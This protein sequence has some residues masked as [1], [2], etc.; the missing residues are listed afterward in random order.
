MTIGA[1]LAGAYIKTRPDVEAPDLQLHFLPFMPGD[2]GRDLADFRGF[3][4][5]M[6]QNRPESRGHVRITS[7]D[8]RV[9]PTFV[10]NHLAE[11][12]DVQTIMAGMKLAKRIGDAMPADVNAREIA[13]GPDG[14]TDEGLL[15]YI[16]STADTG[17]HYSGS[18][19]MGND[20][21]SVVDPKL[22]VRGVDKLRVIDAS[23]L[24]TMVS[25]NINAD[26]IMI[27]EKG[28]DLVKED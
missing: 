24:S 17:F 21:M 22:R 6:Y 27:G 23:I 14:D 1:S 20:D 12:V 10:F 4:L 9:S 19:K 11:N 3:R 15:D 25:G 26:V 28:A 18:A 7:P 5:G 8:P 13:P 16:R 2:K